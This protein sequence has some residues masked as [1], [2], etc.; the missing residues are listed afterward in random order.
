MRSKCDRPAQ[1]RLT[2]DTL[3]CQVWLDPLPE[4]GSM[5]HE[6]CE[7]HAKRMTLPMGWTLSDRRTATPSLFDFEVTNACP[8]VPEVPNAVVADTIITAPLKKATTGGLRRAANMPRGTHPSLSASEF[9]GVKSLFRDPPETVRVPA[10]THPAPTQSTS[11]EPGPRRGVSGLEDG[12]MSVIS[13]GNRSIE[14]VVILKGADAER[15]LSH[16]QGA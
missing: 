10:P 3:R 6:I 9:F 12:T 1:V 14:R 5:V 8:P 4:F 15:D 7:F 2:Y 16:R 13:Y 11:T